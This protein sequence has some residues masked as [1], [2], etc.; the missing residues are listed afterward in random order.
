MLCG[1]VSFL[2]LVGCLRSHSSWGF[3]AFF[4]FLP[5]CFF[6]VGSL[7][8]QMHREILLL[9]ERIS[10]LEDK[11]LENKDSAPR[12]ARFRTPF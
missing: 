7:M 2:S 1:V 11:V 12:P 5:T 10:D 9:R 3:A 6:Y 8:M 4:A